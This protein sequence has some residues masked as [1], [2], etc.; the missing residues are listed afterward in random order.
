VNPEQ[1][2]S[3]IPPS[4]G[5]G[6]DSATLTSNSSDS[7]SGEGTNEAKVP[8]AI[9]ANPTEQ[10]ITSSGVVGVNGTPVVYD[11]EFLD[12]PE[13]KTGKHRTVLSLPSFRVGFFFAQKICS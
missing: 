2:P 7:I 11:P 5:D 13:L 12:D 1:P 4:T 6:T 8:Q 9:S 3:G 10:P